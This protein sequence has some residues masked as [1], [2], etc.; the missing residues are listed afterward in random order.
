MT[1]GTNDRQ[2]TGQ[3]SE[4]RVIP[5]TCA[6]HRGPAGFTNLVVSKRNGQVELDPHADGS[7][8]LT[9][10]KAA[11]TQLFNTLGEWLG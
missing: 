3:A 11:A 2:T 5:A 1:N 7:C 9:L 4:R 10:D 6:L 8:K